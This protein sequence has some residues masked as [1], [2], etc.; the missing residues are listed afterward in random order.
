MPRASFDARMSA[1]GGVALRTALAFLDE[2]DAPQLHLATSQ[3]PFSLPAPASARRLGRSA[4][5]ALT[6]ERERLVARVAPD[7]HEPV[8]HLVCAT[9]RNPTPLRGV[10][11]ADAGGG[12]GATIRH[13]P[14]RA[15]GAGAPG[16]SAAPRVQTVHQPDVTTHL[17]ASPAFA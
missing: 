9:R 13:V 7:H 4:F 3:A 14:P 17:R 10:L 12:A 5:G 2:P 11:G 16:R 8:H 1:S 15:L 6:M